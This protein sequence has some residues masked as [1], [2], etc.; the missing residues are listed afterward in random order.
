[1]LAH[2]ARAFRRPIGVDLC[3]PMLE[4]AR[5]DGFEVLAGDAYRLPFADGVADALTAFSFLHHLSDWR[6]FVRE[7]VRVLKP[8]GW[9]YSDWDPN[10]RTRDRSAAFKLGRDAL[11]ALLDRIGIVK[12]PRYYRPDVRRVAELAEYGWHFGDPLDGRA[13]ADELRSLGVSAPRLIFHD[14]CPTIDRPHAA[15]ALKRV[16]RAA[17][18]ALA[19]QLDLLLRGA[20]ARAEYFLLLGCKA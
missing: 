20:D 18:L 6:A 14:D 11:V 5:C 8:G 13:I 9:F 2:A 4:R 7:A 12:A 19:G 16:Q 10:G 17:T 1:V 3:I 15:T